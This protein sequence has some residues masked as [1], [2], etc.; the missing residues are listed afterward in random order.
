MLINIETKIEQKALIFCLIARPL[1]N[2]EVLMFLI[3]NDW[4]ALSNLC[5]LFDHFTVTLAR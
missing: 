4:L 1:S 3:H 5:D 2:E